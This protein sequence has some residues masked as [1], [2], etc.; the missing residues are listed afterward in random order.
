MIAPTWIC[1][2]RIDFDAFHK[3]ISDDWDFEK[4]LS[5]QWQEGITASMGQK[6]LFQ[7]WV[8]CIT[9]HMNKKKG[10]DYDEATVKTYLKRRFGIRIE[11]KDLETGE[12]MTALKSTTRYKKG[13]MTA[14][15]NEVEDF[16][17]HIGCT[18]PYWGEYLETRKAI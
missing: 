8:R 16:A 3:R 10:N 14:L 17:A 12:P 7:V 9:A 13:E 1:R 15:M 11:S 18:L 4:P 6:S 2:C 5:I